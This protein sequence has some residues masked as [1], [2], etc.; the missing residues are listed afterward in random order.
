MVQSLLWTSSDLF[1]LAIVAAVVV[2]V[3]V[4][5][6]DSRVLTNQSQ[7]DAVSTKKYL[8]GSR[9]ALIGYF[10]LLLFLL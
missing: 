5:V 3:V 6:V 7:I 9:R 2:V 8:V 10:F 1:Q 4:I